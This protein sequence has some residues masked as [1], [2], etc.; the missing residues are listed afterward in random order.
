MKILCSSLYPNLSNSNALP[1]RISVPSPQLYKNAGIT[2]HSVSQLKGDRQALLF[3]IYFFK[4]YLRHSDDVEFLLRFLVP[5]PSSFSEL[6]V[7][8]RNTSPIHSSPL[9]HLFL[10]LCVPDL[11]P[12]EPSVY[13]PVK[14]FVDSMR[15]KVWLFSPSCDDGTCV[16]TFPPSPP[17]HS[18]S[19][20]RSA[21]P[22]D[23]RDRRPF[24]GGSRHNHPRNCPERPE[25]GNGVV[26]VAACSSSRPSVPP[27]SVHNV[28]K[29]M[30]C[31][32]VQMHFISPGDGGL[33]ITAHTTHT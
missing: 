31:L 13:T 26:V 23:P 24:C 2:A 25:G 3:A 16:N 27:S 6:A 21:D 32:S 20:G 29:T 5:L 28:R 33:P 15:P 7:E 14:V 12:Q 10:C 1:T 11:L 8:C 9:C 17:S 18:G 22:P 4:A 19:G 30:Q